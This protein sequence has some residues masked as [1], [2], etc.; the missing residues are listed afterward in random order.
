[1]LSEINSPQQFASS[2][3]VYDMTSEVLVRLTFMILSEM[4]Q[5]RLSGFNEK[6]M[7][8]SFRINCN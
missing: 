3:T 5:E 2:L 1:M 4:A 7:N 6:D 8:V